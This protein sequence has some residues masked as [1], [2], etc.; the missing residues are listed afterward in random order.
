M[1]NLD[2]RLSFEIG[3][4]TLNAIAS[5]YTL[6]HSNRGCVNGVASASRFLKII[7]LFCKRAL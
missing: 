5:I 3:E 4:M 6:V 7:G 1:Y 2:N